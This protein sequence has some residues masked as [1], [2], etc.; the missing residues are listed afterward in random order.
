[1]RSASIL[2]LL[3]V[4]FLAVPSAANAQKRYDPGASDTEIKIGNIIP[5]SGPASAYGVIGKTEAAYFNKINA[6][7]GINGRKIVFISYDD[8]YSPPKTVEQARRLVESDEVLLI[9]SSLGT[10][11]NTAI[12]KYLNAKKVPQLFVATGAAKWNDPKHFPW[13][14]GFQPSYQHEGQIYAKY[15]LQNHPDSRIGIL[16][17]NDDY[18]K[19]YLK[20]LKDALAGRMQIVAEL[21]YEVS[22]TTVDSQIVNL[23]ASGADVFYNVATP[24]FAAQA[25]RKVAEIGWKP[26]HLLNGVSANIGA[27]LK[28]AGL[29]NSL[30]VLSAAYFKDQ[31]DP[32]WKN[33]SGYKEWAAFLDRYYPD[34]DRTNSSVVSGF[35]YAQAMVRVLEQCGDDL[36]R[37]NVR[38]QA[39]NFNNVA[40][41]MLLPGITANTSPQDY[42]PLKQMQMRRFAGEHWEL[43]GPVIV[44]ELGGS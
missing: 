29:D 14:M 36:T 26:V 21:P 34:A 16:Y 38:R 23:K 18:G 11:P 22:D 5:Y 30:G 40:F 10:A 25:I 1:M 24:K 43:F 6:E 37:D 4:A 15:L 20:G 32:V 2:G 12:Q 42:A 44:A 7:G 33:D 19:D 8:G 31:T 39:A 13:T 28:P 41:G 17:Q 27:V 3:V 9:F 35:L